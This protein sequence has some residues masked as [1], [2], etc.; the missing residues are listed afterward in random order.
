MLCASAV[1]STRHP[2][3]GGGPDWGRWASPAVQVD[4]AQA[5]P[6]IATIAVLQ[7]RAAVEAQAFNDQLNQALNSRICI[8]QAKGI[9]AEHLALDMEQSF[10]HLRGYARSN[11]R[12]LAEVAQEVI[13]GVLAPATLRA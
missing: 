13:E 12:R 6:D 8:E 10:A 7:H 4:V 11:N 2:A 9:V 5:M 1:S 3:W